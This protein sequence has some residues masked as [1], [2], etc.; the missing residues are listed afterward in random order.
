MKKY[1]FYIL[2]LL[3]TACQE[4]IDINFK[5]S[6]PRIMIEGYY[7]NDSLSNYVRVSRTTD[8]T[9]DKISIPVE[10][11]DIQIRI[12]ART[13]DNIDFVNNG[14]YSISA[15]GQINEEFEIIVN[16]NDTLYR[17]ESEILPTGTIDS[18]E[19]IFYEESVLKERG[20]YVKLYTNRTTE[21]H[22][23]RV[24]RKNGISE[25]MDD[26]LLTPGYVNTS[27]F[28]LPYMFEL[29][30]TVLVE[31]MSLNEEAFQYLDQLGLYVNNL[32][33]LLNYKTE[34]PKGNFSNNALGLFYGTSIAKK[35]IIIK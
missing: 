19:V 1:I 13:I 21:Y 35:E 32:N 33:D 29:G 18:A 30:D 11:A 9:D 23:W 28:E 4:L 26:I 7:S 24:I 8:F 15:Q 27:F 31:M 25:V 22:R 12:S 3:L 20:Y 17:A 5:E 14:Y 2:L 6:D 34:N 16:I 10:N